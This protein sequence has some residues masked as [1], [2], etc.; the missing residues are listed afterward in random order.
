MSKTAQTLIGVGVLGVGA[1]LGAG[2][3]GISSEAGY[4]GVGPNFLPWLVAA[5]MAL[6]GGF[7]LWEARSGGFRAM[8]EP[9]G[10]EH[11]HWPGFAWV[12][13]GILLNAALITTIGF[14]LSCALCFV[15]AVRGFKSSDGR[16]DL[17][18]KAW[19]IDLAVGILIS[20]PVYWMFTQALA[21][22]LP[23]LTNSGWL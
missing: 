8:E 11:G 22:N 14:I 21:I 20:A 5:F 1:L 17:S 12:S 15:L 6:C 16:L 2:A 10:N 7:L 13:A 18:A 9:D 4:S 3:I 19:A 23:G